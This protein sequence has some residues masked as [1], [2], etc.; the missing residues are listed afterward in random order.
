MLPVILTDTDPF[1]LPPLPPA[2]RS[3]PPA[4]GASS[5]RCARG[6]ACPAPNSLPCSRLMD[7][8]SVPDGAWPAHGAAGSGMHVDFVLSDA[9]KDAALASAGV[10]LRVAAAAR[11]DPGGLR[12]RT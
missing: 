4:C 8:I 7:V 11:Y 6:P 1:T 3:P 12:A 5:A 2:A 9:F 10:L